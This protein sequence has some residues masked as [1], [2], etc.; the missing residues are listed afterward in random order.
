[1]N[2]F[3]MNKIIN[4]LHIMIDKAING[5]VISSAFDE[6]KMSSLENKLHQYLDISATNKVKLEEEK[7]KI[8]TLISDIS[9]QT[10]TPVS[11]ILLYSELL[12]ESN[13]TDEDK[14]SV[15]MLI[16]QSEKLS[17]LIDSLV[18]I[19]RLETGIISITPKNNSVSAMIKNAL[20]Q[21]KY[22]A[23]QKNITIDYIDI[24]MD[25]NANFDMKWTTEAIYN[26]L[27]NAIKYSDENSRVIIDVTSYNMFCK[28]NIKDNGI[29]IN[30]EE[31]NKIFIRFYRSDDVSD[32]EGVGIGLYLAREIIV[33]N[34]GYIKAT[35]ELNVGS[36]FSV[37]LPLI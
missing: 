11:N 16:C 22:K 3:K 1:M 24:D 17:F 8:N 9:H 12:S 6:S 28:I 34:G 23:I 25:M 32:Y 20:T 10:K 30:K 29:G 37:Y 36:V 14:K 19:S 7:N 21:V 26:I 5:E 2:I 33:N 13:L 18:K 15:D 27:D 35:S 4:N 31:L